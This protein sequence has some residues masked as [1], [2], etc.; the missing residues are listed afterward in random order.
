MKGCLPDNTMINAS[1]AVW[2]HC[3]TASELVARS[4]KALSAD[5]NTASAKIVVSEAPQETQVVS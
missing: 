4:I 2:D 1:V 3:E 5:Q